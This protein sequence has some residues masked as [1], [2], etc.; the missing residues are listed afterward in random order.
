MKNLRLLSAL[1]ACA[2][3]TAP[4]FSVTS[5]AE[6]AAEVTETAE[7]SE[8]DTSD[9]TEV[10]EKTTYSITYRYGYGTGKIDTTDPVPE[11]QFV[12]LSVWALRRD[13]YTHVG[14]TDGEK[15]YK[16]GELIKM[17]AKD[18]V[19]EPVWKPVY[20]IKFENLE[21]YGYPAPSSFTNGTL[22]PG[23]E[24]YLPNLPMHNG[25]AQFEGWL[26]NGDYYPPLSTFQMP[27][28]DTYVE[29]YWLSP[30]KIDY[31]AGDVE[32]VIGNPHYIMNGFYNYPMDIS[33]GE[34]L[35]RLGYKLDGWYVPEQD[36]KKYSFS[37]SFVVPENGITFYADW[38]PLKIG[39]KFNANGGTGKMTNQTEYFD[40]V[41]NIKPCEF[42]KEGYKLL[43]WKNGDNYY[44]PEGAVKVYVKEYGDFMNF[45]AVWI[46]ENRNPGDLNGNGIV[47]IT[48][49]S[50]LS[51][52]IL[53]E[54]EITDEQTLDD[55]DV[56]RDGKVDISDAARMKKFLS[57]ERILLGTGE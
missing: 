2:V 56:E 4:V 36:N 57:K 5:Y 44:L 14:W 30:V 52:H 33:N 42:T 3:M 35:T 39:M 47:D 27:E 1:C 55:A 34:R 53:G 31:F 16:R 21:D 41:V 19:L 25:E 24:I 11:K 49:L 43:G 40:D 32:G 22:S 29:V 6:E 26:V 37:D 10:P 9:T 13:G 18:L 54:A 8:A 45:Q 50:I 38:V 17:P 15:T 23:T 46:E 12:V 7:V 48:D 28:K 51:L 20:T